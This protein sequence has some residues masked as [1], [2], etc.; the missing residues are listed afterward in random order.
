MPLPVLAWPA[1]R[2]RTHLRPTPASHLQ[3]RGLELCGLRMQRLR[4]DGLSARCLRQLAGVEVRS[5]AGHGE[6]LQRAGQTADR[7][8]D[9]RLRARV[10][11][12]VCV[13][14]T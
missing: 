13:K 6:A 2:A 11:A 4:L 12:C 5:G 14:E 9:L 7:G 1:S 8:L 3:A 10:H